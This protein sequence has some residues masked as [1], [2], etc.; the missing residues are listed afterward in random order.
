M[1]NLWKEPV[2]PLGCTG[3]DLRFCGAPE[4][5]RTPNLLIRSQVLY[6]LSYG[7]MPIR[8]PACAAYRVGWPVRSAGSRRGTQDC[9]QAQ[10]TTP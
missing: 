6:P 2:R 1:S 4:G 7:R 9:D 8:R 5:I 10:C 3:S